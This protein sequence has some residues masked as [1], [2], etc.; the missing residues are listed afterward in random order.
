M[1]GAAPLI[2]D[3]PGGNPTMFGLSGQ[4]TA[5]PLTGAAGGNVG[6]GSEHPTHMWIAAVMLAALIGVIFFHVSG[7]RFATDVGVTRG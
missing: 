3:N 6:Y 2:D 4:A 1:P 5:G 7:F